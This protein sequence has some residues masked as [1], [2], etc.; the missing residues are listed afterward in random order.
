[1]LFYLCCFTSEI[2]VSFYIWAKRHEYSFTRTFRYVFQ[3]IKPNNL[4]CFLVLSQ[5]VVKRKTFL[6]FTKGDVHFL[7]WVVVYSSPWGASWPSGLRPTMIKLC[8]T[9]SA[10][11]LRIITGS[12]GV[13]QCA[14]SQSFTG[15]AVSVSRWCCFITT[16]T[17]VW[18]EK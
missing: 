17:V 11:H 1:M 15:E 10:T 3:C 5:R 7:L 8:V 18:T 14:E 9:V 13:N 16:C 6:S 2:N 12:C 4:F